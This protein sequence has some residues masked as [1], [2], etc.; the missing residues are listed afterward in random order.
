MDTSQ[1]RTCQALSDEAPCV[2]REANAP[3]HPNS[4]RTSVSLSS[5]VVWPL[6]AV[7]LALGGGLGLRLQFGSLTVALAYLNGERL[8]VRPVEFA[9]GEVRPG[10]ERELSAAIIN[11]TARDVVVIGCNSTCSCVTTDTFPR[12]IP[13]GAT[14]PLYLKFRPGG[15]LGDVEYVVT[16]FTDSQELPTIRIHVK[17][18]VLE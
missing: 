18:R 1:E 14:Q 17:G 3:G 2:V 9:V 5:W 11:M 8:I 12:T 4:A 16:Y 13:R 7:V 6:A 10:D 15:Q